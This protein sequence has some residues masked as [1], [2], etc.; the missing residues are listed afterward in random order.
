[1][2]P[3]GTHVAPIEIP[4]L[5]HLRLKKFLRKRITPQ[6]EAATPKAT[7]AKSVKKKATK[8]VTS[9]PKAKAKRAAVSSLD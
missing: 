6:F 2:I 7:K 3:G 9:K 8:R 4:E 1:M 5:F